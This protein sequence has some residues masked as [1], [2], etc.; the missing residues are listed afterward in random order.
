MNKERPAHLMAG[1]FCKMEVIMYRKRHRRGRRLASVILAAVMVTTAI[2]AQ[3]AE[4]GAPENLEDIFSSGEEDSVTG[5]DDG[6][7]TAA[8]SPETGTQDTTS[9]ISEGTVTPTVTPSADD[10]PTVTPSADNTP[11]VTPLPSETPIPSV[12]PALSV[13]PT[14]AP[15]PTINPEKEVMLR[16]IDG[17]GNECEQLRTVLEWNESLILP[18]VPDSQAPDLWK[19]EKDE[20]LNDAITLKGGDL[21][22]LKKGESWNI[23][24]QNGIL[25]FY[26]PKKCTISLYNNS[27]TGVFPNGILQVYETNTAILPDMPYSKYINYGWTDTK[28]SSEI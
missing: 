19:L 13:T 5:T 20:K 26:M 7:A 17:E 2:P 14:P 9:P 12:T 11:T 23:F 8:S 21:L 16:F 10:T 15:T 27:G 24:I 4:F 25:N 6:T 1:R 3:A 18:N 28:G 22:T